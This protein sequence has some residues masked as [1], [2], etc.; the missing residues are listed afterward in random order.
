LEDPLSSQILENIIFNPI[1]PQHIVG[2]LILVV[3]LL[4]SAFVSGSE[5]ALFAL[6]P[7]HIDELKKEQSKIS[8]LILSLLKLPEKLLATILIV[9]NLVNVGIVILTSF[10]TSSLFDFS[11]NPTLGFLFQVVVITF[12]LLLFGEIIPKVYA[13]RF[14]LGFSKM[15]A[16]A[17]QIL[18]Y[19]FHPF[20]LVLTQTSGVIE[21]RLSRKKQQVSIDELTEALDLTEE[22]VSM[23]D[24]I[25]KGI[26][27]F[28]NIGVS[29]IMRSR[30]DVISI[31]IND[32]FSKVKEII[33]QSGYSRIP[34]IE[35][36][37]DHVKGVLYV[38]DL[39][40]HL[41]KSNTFRWQSV[42]RPPFFVPE[43]KKIDDLLKD[44]QTKKVHM[45]ILVD[46]YGGAS[47]I[48]TME[49][50]LEEIIGDINDE[51][52][53]IEQLYTKIDDNVYQFE[54]KT[55]LLDFCKILKLKDNYFEQAKADAETIAGFI[56]E[57]KGEIPEKR[58]QFEYRNLLFEIKAVDFRR[59]KQVLVTVRPSSQKKINTHS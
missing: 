2:V 20:S 35:E 7:Q 47:G 56:L 24:Q 22:E 40:P 38:K 27:N 57:L 52:D 6:K 19:V 45:A 49:D 29:E 8:L 13:S 12:I 25:L 21:K 34:V 51:F 30:M 53:N 9:N 39:L 32:E 48:V 43:S 18:N 33:K 17:L 15:T 58:E 44:F 31:H 3:L 14:P 5:V 11:L 41:H 36:T 55:L 16:P 1:A 46:E 59:I 50:V 37:F 42:I 10:I 23:D 4:V 54:G 28:A 26:V